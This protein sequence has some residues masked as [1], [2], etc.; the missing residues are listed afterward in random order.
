MA[1]TDPFEPETVQA[2]TDLFAL[3]TIAPFFDDT[4]LYG[5]KQPRQ[6][7]YYQI[8]GGKVTY[9]WYV[10]R[11]AQA[12]ADKDRLS[13][14]IYHFTMAYDSAVPNTFVYTY[15]A[16]GKTSQDDGGVNGAYAAVGFQ[17]CEFWFYPVLS[18]P[19]L[20]SS[21]MQC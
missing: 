14:S 1:A 8:D 17:G 12:P 6:G 21:A 18:S 16:M 2:W 19:I 10:G 5:K 11:S 20:L 15:Y 13:Q 9:E 3:N 4:F 7:I